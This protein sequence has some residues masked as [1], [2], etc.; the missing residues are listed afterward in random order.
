M[1]PH[2]D[3]SQ[4]ALLPLLLGSPELAEWIAAR[5]A[6]EDA[7]KAARAG[8]EQAPTPTDPLLGLA[9]IPLAG[10]VNSA[11][12][13]TPVSPVAGERAEPTMRPH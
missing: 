12:N 7:V 8:D 2:Q 9:A 3:L 11:G 10:L 4:A 1:R 6:Q 5:I 13:V